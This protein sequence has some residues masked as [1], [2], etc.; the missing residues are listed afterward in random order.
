M[1]TDIDR[2]RRHRIKIARR[3]ARRAREDQFLYSF[4]L[5]WPGGFFAWCW[6]ICALL[7]PPGLMLLSLWSLTRFPRRRRRD[8]GAE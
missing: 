8:R 2:A 7:I 5:D 1:T 3:T 4:A 6:G